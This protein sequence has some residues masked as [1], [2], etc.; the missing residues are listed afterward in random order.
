M[1]KEKINNKNK[2]KIFN[3]NKEKPKVLLLGTGLVQSGGVSPN[4]RKIIIELSKD[5]N[6]TKGKDMLLGVPHSIQ[7]TIAIDSDDQ[8]RYS[9]YKYFFENEYPYYQNDLIKEILKIK[10]DA[11]LTTNYSYDL[12]DNIVFGFPKLPDSSKR[13]YAYST[14]NAVDKKYLIHNYYRMNV[15]E[16]VIQDIWHIH[17]EARKRK[18]MV[19]THD[20]YAKSINA[21]LNY[22]KMRKKDYTYNRDNLKFESWVDY[23]IFGD[24]YIVGLGYDFSEFDLWWLMNRRSRE[25]T[26]FGNVYFFTPQSKFFEHTP[27]ETALMRLGVNVEHCGMCLTGDKEEDNTIFKEFYKRSINKIKQIIDSKK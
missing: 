5:E 8:K 17:G 9:K 4:W 13:K 1:R 7:A 21:I 10:F 2:F 18:S 27:I 12:E 26:G 24:I 25:K 19:L 23:F 6:N 20:E 11:V 3:V 14:T 16:E 15:N 22:S